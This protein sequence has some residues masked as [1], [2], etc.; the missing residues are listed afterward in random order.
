MTNDHCMFLDGYVVITCLE[1]ITNRP[2]GQLLLDYLTDAVISTKSTFNGVPNI[3]PDSR[4]IATVDNIQ[5][6]HST[7]DNG[8]VTIIVQKITRKLA[9]HAFVTNCATLL[10]FCFPQFTPVAHSLTRSLGYCE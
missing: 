1:P 9:S 3:S 5:K 10:D 6:E 8:G 7:Q 2:Q 4:H